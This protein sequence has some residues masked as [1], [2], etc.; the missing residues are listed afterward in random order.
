MI[1]IQQNSMNYDLTALLRKRGKFKI[2]LNKELI[3]EDIANWERIGDKSE[4]TMGY[5]EYLGNLLDT[6]DNFEITLHIKSGMIKTYDIQLVNNSKYGINVYRYL[7]LDVIALDY[8]KIADCIAVDMM[9][10]D[11][12]YTFNELEK[13]FKN[14]GIVTVYE[15][16]YLDNIIDTQGMYE[17]SKCL[18][19]EDSQYNIHRTNKILDYFGS[20]T[21]NNTYYKDVVKYSC[22]KAMN[23]VAENLILSRY[24]VIGVD[25]THVYIV[26]NKDIDKSKIASCVRVFGRKFEVTPKVVKVRRCKDE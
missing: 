24:D 10:R 2:S 6:P 11:I 16:K 23:I 7:N 4:E 26:S 9:Y 5:I 21:F 19:I 25:E 14:I 15:L 22:L 8:T 1:T 3:K 18:R 13:Q 12:G 20:K 17:D